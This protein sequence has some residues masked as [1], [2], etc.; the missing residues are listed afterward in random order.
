MNILKISIISLMLFSQSI[1]IAWAQTEIVYNKNHCPDIT[2]LYSTHPD[3]P[4]RYGYPLNYFNLSIDYQNQLLAYG[5]QKGDKVAEIGAASGWILGMFAIYTDSVSYFAQDIDT[6]HLN[7]NELSKM[8]AY[9][10]NQKSGPQTNSFN[11]VIGTPTQTNLP[12]QYFDVIFIDNSYHEFTDK[13]AMIKDIKTK[14]KPDGR[15]II[16][17][18][19]TNDYF[20]FRHEGCNILAN[21]EQEIKELMEKNGLYQTN[22]W[23]PD[24]NVY[25]H[26]TFEMNQQKSIDFLNGKRRF[27]ELIQL[28]D[29]KL[30][31]NQD[32]VDTLGK[33]LFDLRFEMEDY[34]SY[35]ALYDYFMSLGG[36]FAQNKLFDL[37][38]KVYYVGSQ[39]FPELSYFYEAQADIYLNRR[40]K[41]VD[42]LNLL[43]NANNRSDNSFYIYNAMDI[44]ALMAYYL[45]EEAPEHKAIEMLDE[46]I[47]ETDYYQD[48]FPQVAINLQ[49]ARAYRILTDILL[50]YEISEVVLSDYDFAQISP[51]DAIDMAIQLDSLNPEYYFKRAQMHYENGLY[52]KAKSDLDRTIY[53]S[54][55]NPIYFR[56]RGKINKDLGD[57][58]GSKKDKEMFKSLKK[59]RRQMG[60]TD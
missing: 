14:L 25:N 47:K 32:F 5:I 38:Y 42:L 11:Y 15:L 54:P 39:M 56:N 57:V 45:I 1:I 60:I 27:P 10:S 16:S 41:N 13:E 55:Y 49:K 34:Y 3:R 31:K 59:W 21:S 2:S 51:L 19:I 35:E 20:T 52:H 7:E 40:I 18:L 50:Q 29:A 17:E 58:E 33:K 4:F 22:S 28:S 26:L 23:L 43:N 48:E 24:G 9:F 12:E 6:N 36:E 30:M 8:A 44:K 53:L 37:A 46:A